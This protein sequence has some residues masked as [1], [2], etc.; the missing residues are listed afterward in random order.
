MFGRL[1]Q[2]NLYLFFLLV[3]SLV[4]G[5]SGM[6]KEKYEQTISGIYA[7]S[8][9]KGEIT[10]ESVE[11]QGYFYSTPYTR[12]VFDYTEIVGDKPV[13]VNDTMFFEHKTTTLNQESEAVGA[14]DL[15]EFSMYSGVVQSFAFQEE[16]VSLAKVIKKELSEKIEIEK[17]HLIEVEPYLMTFPLLDSS[18]EIGSFSD[19]FA[20]YKKDVANNQKAGRPFKGYYDINVEKYMKLGLILVEISYENVSEELFPDT[21]DELDRRVRRKI[22][23]LDT[24]TFYDGIYRLS[25]DTVTE[26]GGRT[27]GRSYT[28]HVKDKKISYLSYGK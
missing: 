2:K 13:T 26:D 20:L 22:L 9:L 19:N 11:G 27:G 6:S 25:F 14:E 4:A 1:K 10:V 28:F 23:R 8:R 5:C 7:Q 18:E 21:I 16:S 15:T 3:L 24:S 12:V 17:L